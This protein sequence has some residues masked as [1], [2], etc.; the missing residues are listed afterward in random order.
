MENKK[1]VVR[2]GKCF[3]GGNNP[4]LIQSMT[5]TKTE[6]V[7]STVEQIKELIIAGCQAVR[8]SVNTLAAAQS[9]REIKSRIDVNL[10]GDIHFDPNLAIVAMDNGIDKI[11][12]NPGNIKKEKLVKIIEKAKEKD[13]SI[14]IGVNS[15]SIDKK[16]LREDIDRIQAM[17]LSIKEMVSFFQEHDFRNLVL[18]AKVSDV[19]D[20]I[21]INRILNE[22]FDY[23]LHLGV[24][25]S[26]SYMRGSIKSSIG[27]GSLLCDDIGST[28]RVSLTEDPV[29]EV[30]VAI[31]ILKATGHRKG[32]NIISCPTCAR[33]ESN[34]IEIVKQAEELLKPYD[35]PMN[36]A[37]M[38]CAVN[39]PGEAKHADIGIAGVGDKFALFKKG[40]VIMTADRETALNFIV[41]NVRKNAK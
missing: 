6:D 11:R 34:L 20:N 9:I 36:V 12:I 33:T 38:G 1:R 24:T 19:R 26:G 32:L 21:K 15:G 41:E 22:K 17:Y 23:P 28:I 35:V 8:V 5:N 25:E 37:I 18:S 13:V 16:Y 30:P 14:R 10:I 39:G 27:I 29:K 3:I 2:I 4:V 40:Q 31:D 7:D